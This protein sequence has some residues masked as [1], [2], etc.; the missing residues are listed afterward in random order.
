[1]IPKSI[2]GFLC[3]FLRLTARK[4]CDI[5]KI[6]K[7]GG[8]SMIRYQVFSENQWLYPDTVLEK[9]N[10]AELYA[11]RGSDVCFQILMDYVL[12]E[13]EKVTFSFSYDGCDAEVMQLVPAHVF[14]NSAAGASGVAENYDE[15]KHFVTRKAPFDVYDI[16]KPLDDQPTEAGRAAFYVRINVAE[17]TPVGLLE[18][19]LTIQL[20]RVVVQ[21][22]VSIKIYNVV[23]PK[24][25]DAAFHMVNWIYFNDG[26]KNISLA[27]LHRTEEFSEE[28]YGILENYFQN[29]LDMRNDTLMLP[30]GKPLRDAAGKV[31]GFDFAEVARVGNLALRY[32]FRQIMGGFVATWP[33]WNAPNID[34]VWDRETTVSSLDGYRQLKLYFT[35]VQKLI[36]DN[37]WGQ[38][39]WQCLVDEPQK[40]NA[41]DYR[42]LSAICRKF[43]PGVVINDPIETVDI[44]GALDIWVVKQAVYE[45]YLEEFRKL[46]EMGETFWIYSCGFPAG[47]T[48]NRIIDLPLTVSRLMMWM[49]YA[50]DAPGFLHFGYALHNEDP[51]DTNYLAPRNRLFPPGNAHIVYPG[52]KGPWYSVRGHS[53]RTGAV[54]FELLTILGKKNQEKAK[55]LVAKLCRGFD[56]YDPSAE[57]FDAVRK[58]LLDE[59]G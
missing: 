17:N 32:G 50:Y 21:V 41:T 31:I 14:H 45:K 7:T 53:Q 15:V 49:C 19:A 13:G 5:L 54:D 35:G 16:T 37:N 9:E 10:K 1:M 52:T 3:L 51:R 48:M 39:Y 34:L 11:A 47:K 2:I 46:Q 4:C 29:Q 40:Y 6:K 42:A 24:L 26:I 20:E 58:E 23:V 18:T 36:A 43:L 33:T 38:Q 30:V 8:F 27:N 12:T 22:P 56:D 25:A 57:L 28:Y 44:E 59:I 55:Q